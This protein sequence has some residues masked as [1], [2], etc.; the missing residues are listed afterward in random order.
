MQFLITQAEVAKA[1]SNSQFQLMVVTNA[2]TRRARVWEFDGRDVKRRFALMPVSYFARP[3]W[4]P[5][6]TNRP[7]HSS[8][9]IDAT[10]TPR[11]R[12]A[13]ALSKGSRH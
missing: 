10:A 3:K 7:A 1:A 5:G 11:H 8:T 13:W 2:R 9:L 6:R 12:R 4:P